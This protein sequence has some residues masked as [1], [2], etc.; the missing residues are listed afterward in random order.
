ML[1]GHEEGGLRWRGP[2]A[3]RRHEHVK[4][5]EWRSDGAHLSVQ[6]VEAEIDAAQ[7]GHGGQLLHGYVC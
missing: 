6:R 2:C 7:G 4:L 1:G 5:D 3:L